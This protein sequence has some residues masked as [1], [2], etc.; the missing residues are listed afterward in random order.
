MN[1]IA[2]M[3]VCYI[4]EDQW[5]TR[6]EAVYAAAMKGRTVNTRVNK[7]LVQALESS[8]SD[9]TPPAVLPTLVPSLV[10]I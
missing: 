6:V 10:K 1:L 9:I 8:P 5:G 7:S 3:R 4:V 2:A